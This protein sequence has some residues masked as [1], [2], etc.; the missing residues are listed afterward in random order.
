VRHRRSVARQPAVSDRTRPQADHIVGPAVALTEPRVEASEL[1]DGSSHRVAGARAL[2]DP[3]VEL[4]ADDYV[5]AA[6]RQ[7]RDRARM[8]GSL[9]RRDLLAQHPLPSQVVHRG[10]VPPEPRDI[11]RGPQRADHSA[12]IWP[13]DDARLLERVDAEA[14]AEPPPHALARYGALLDR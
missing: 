8:C 14:P 12:R 1:L 13:L 11:V 6:G 9:D 5:P 4:A 7:R 2:V 10:A 3:D